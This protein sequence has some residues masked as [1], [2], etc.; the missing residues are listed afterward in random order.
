MVIHWGSV[1]G[2]GVSVLQLSV[3]RG[4][5]CFHLAKGGDF[6][7]LSVSLILP[8]MASVSTTLGGSFIWAPLHHLHSPPPRSHWMAASPI[9]TLSSWHKGTL[10]G[11]PVSGDAGESPSHSPALSVC[12]CTSVPCS[13]WSSSFHPFP[14]VCPSRLA[15]ELSNS[16]AFRRQVGV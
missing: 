4:R 12:L 2:G 8:V 10:C 14:C 9:V 6:C 7:F 11:C 16:R 1:E 15:A 13:A 3:K 5:L